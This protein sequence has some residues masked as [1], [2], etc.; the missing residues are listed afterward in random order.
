MG[1]VTTEG[2]SIVICQVIEYTDVEDN[3]NELPSLSSSMF[4]LFGKVTGMSFVSFIQK[5]QHQF[6]AI[7]VQMEWSTFVLD[8]I[9][10]SSLYYIDFPFVFMRRQGR[11]ILI[12]LLW[13]L[14]LNSI[15]GWQQY[16]YVSSRNVTKYLQYFIL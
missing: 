5:P 15:L 8:S 3:E 12:D 13:L 11:L 9:E 10:F 1:N 16:C 6:E 7:A 2:V 14:S 4:V